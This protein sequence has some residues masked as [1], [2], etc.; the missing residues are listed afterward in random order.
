MGC[1]MSMESAPAGY[2]VWRVSG[3]RAGVGRVCREIAAACHADAVQKASTGKG[4]MLVRECVLLEQDAEVQRQAAI[5]AWAA[6]RL[7][8][9]SGIGCPPL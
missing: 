3:H 9:G 6:L 8:S 1:S 4:F 2:R 7:R 5:R